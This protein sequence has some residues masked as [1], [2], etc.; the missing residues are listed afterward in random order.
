MAL[1][2][3]RNQMAVTAEPNRTGQD[4]LKTGACTDRADQ[5]DGRGRHGLI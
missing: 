3:Q 4:T 1:L 5:M 2:T